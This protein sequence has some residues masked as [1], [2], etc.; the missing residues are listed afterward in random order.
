MCRIPMHMADWIK[1]LYAFLTFNER[2]ILAHAGAI[3]HEMSREMAE[4][5]YEKFNQRRISQ[6]DSIEG[7][8]DKTISRLT[9]SNLAKKQ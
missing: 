6:K 8:F 7:D 9:D 3:S 1:K 2:E 4:A 5:E